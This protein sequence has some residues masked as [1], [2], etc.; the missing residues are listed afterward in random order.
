M[1]STAVATPLAP[2]P[3][4]PTNLQEGWAKV[5]TSNYPGYDLSIRSKRSAAAT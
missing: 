3:M 4:A 5:R 2:K 1:A